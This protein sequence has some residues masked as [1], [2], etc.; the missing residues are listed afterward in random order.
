MGNFTKFE[1]GTK[2]PNLSTDRNFFCACT[3]GHLS[4]ESV[5]K[6]LR[7]CDNKKNQRWPTVAMFVDGPEFFLVLAQLGTE[8]NI[9]TKFQKNPTSGPGGDAIT[10][11]V[12]RRTVGRTDGLTDV[13]RPYEKLL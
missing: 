13:P 5:K 9:L 10:R 6:F 2:R 8:G 12:Y 4:F 7:R 1:P 3:P 11:Y